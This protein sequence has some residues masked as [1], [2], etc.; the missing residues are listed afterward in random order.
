MHHESSVLQHSCVAGGE[1]P[2]GVARIGAVSVAAKQ[3]RAPHLDHRV[4]HAQLHTVEHLA[5]EHDC[6]RGLGHAVGGPTVGRHSGGNGGST[7]EHDPVRRWIHAAEG[8]GHH[9][10]RGGAVDGGS[11]DRVRIEAIVHHEPESVGEGPHDDCDAGDVGGR[12]TAH[13]YVIGAGA[14]RGRGHAGRGSER[15][16]GVHD[17]LRHARAPRGR[18]DERVTG[19]DGAAV[20]PMPLTVPVN[21]RPGPQCVEQ[22]S[23]RRLG[24]AWIHRE[25]RI[26]AVPDVEQGGQERRTGAVDGDELGHAARIGRRFGRAGSGPPS[27]GA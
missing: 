5:V 6:A 25:H 12:Q 16:E 17:A 8:G 22:G 24:Q 26:A 7:D 23:A 10:D 20:E 2:I 19:F 18:D 3:H 4:A 14:E 15:L 21:Q 11:G 27:C 9:R 13:P 1:P